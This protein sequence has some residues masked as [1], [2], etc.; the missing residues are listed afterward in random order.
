M[1]G[2]SLNPG[3]VGKC[4]IT[5]EYIYICLQNLKGMVEEKPPDVSH[6]DLEP[7]RM[8]KDK[9]KQ[10]GC[11]QPTIKDMGEPILHTI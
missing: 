8:K 2:F 11:C 7:A 9:K 1:K 5:A 4:Y 6:A 3:A 10:A